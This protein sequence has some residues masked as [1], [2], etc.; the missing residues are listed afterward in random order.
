MDMATSNGR[1]D[2]VTL[3]MG[4]TLVN[5]DS[6]YDRTLL[7]MARTAG[8]TVTL[9]DIRSAQRVF[10]Q[11]FDTESIT[12]TWEPTPVNDDAIGQEIDRRICEKLGIT[13]AAFLAE[14]RLQAR[15]AFH[16]PATYTVYPEVYEILKALRRAVP[17]LGILS[18]WGWH[19]PELC[20]QLGL[21]SYFDFIVV[22]AR[23]GCSK[24]NPCIFR[25]MLRQAGTTPERTLHVGDSLSADVRGAQAVG[26]TGVL[27]DRAGTVQPDGYP[28]VHSL[29]EVLDLL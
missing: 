27:I 24:P 9:D 3:D 25:E 8:H 18:N 11:E 22:S 26:V 21:A 14:L 15:R 29:T 6:G 10:W 12:R 5:L 7:A 13:D 20:E 23:V 19:L 2:A 16:D 4:F 28:V 1:Y 17:R